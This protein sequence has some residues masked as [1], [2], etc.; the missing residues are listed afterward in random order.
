M[1]RCD[2]RLARFENS[3]PYVINNRI[4]ITMDDMAR[5]A[6]V[7]V[8]T[9]CVAK[10]ASGLVKMFKG[11]SINLFWQSCLRLLRNGAEIF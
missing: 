10:L 2:G 1:R 9:S 6:G 5:C 11:G 3:G 4:T 8:R 7:D